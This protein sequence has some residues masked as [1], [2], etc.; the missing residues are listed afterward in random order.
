MKHFIFKL[1][2][3]LSRLKPYVTPV[4]KLSLVLLTCLLL[5]LSVKALYG[6]TQ[7]LGLGQKTLLS[8]TKD[9][10]DILDSTDNLTN[11]LLLGIRGEGA[12][13]PDLTDT[14]I[15]ISYNHST[16]ST[17]LLTIPRD[18]YITSLKTKINS[19]YHY[20][21]ATLVRGAIQEAL[22]VPI[23]YT[24]IIN[25]KGFV[26]TIDV[27]GGVT[28][29]VENSFTD[30]QYPLPGKETVL[31]EQNRYE[32]ISFTKGSQIMDGEKALKYVRS[33][34]AVGEEGT[35]FARSR[36]QELLVSALKQKVLSPDLLF[37]ETKLDSLLDVFRTNFI[38]DIDLNLFPSLG[39]I[40]LT[41]TDTSLKTIS[42]STEKDDGSLA[43]LETGNPK[44]YGNQWVLIAKDNNWEALR[45]Y[46]TN[47]LQGIQ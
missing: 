40:G 27:L 21:G 14:L 16:K 25:F 38:T 19:V 39:K 18:L 9:P 4:S 30:A 36:R 8:I 43:I 34:H 1:S 45:Q 44:F 20:G 29:D 6:L 10:K 12:D 47:K 42:L 24:A 37:N 5:F 17:T 13:S 2:R 11:L 7:R 15:V 41:L 3:S 23:H 26:E 33:R 32:T 35:D 28:I 46:V 31:P 22:G